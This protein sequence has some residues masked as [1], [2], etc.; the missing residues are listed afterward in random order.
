MLSKVW[1]V[2][3]VLAVCVIFFAVQT[4][5]VWFTKQKRYPEP[6]SSE[7]Q[8]F[9]QDKQLVKR[10]LPPESAYRAIVDKNL[11]SA[12]RKEYL[13][14][15]PD[16]E[17][18]LSLEPEGEIKPFE[19]FGKNVVLYGV[20]IWDDVRKALI[21]NPSSKRGES[22]D[23]WVEKG[24]ILLEV[25]RHNKVATLKVDDILKDRILVK[26][27]SNKYE[28]LLY[29]KENP[30]QRETIRMDE[31]PEV[32]IPEVIAPS[33]PSQVP[34]PAK[35]AQALRKAI[36]ENIRS[37]SKKTE[38]QEEPGSETGTS[39]GTAPESEPG[40]EPEPQYEIINTPFGEIK[41]RIN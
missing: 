39:P 11:F 20:L 16:P 19:G 12:D 35:T 23:I 15:T 22:K 1:F 21:T 38:S 25:K 18:D 31:A 36:L 10:N 5:D 13:P 6:I 28:I 41:R 40:A 24:D 26:D 30:R 9:Q 17:I 37:D 7:K 14:P 34:V 27:E 29:D 32:I 4:F 8:E 2:N 33:E 3:I